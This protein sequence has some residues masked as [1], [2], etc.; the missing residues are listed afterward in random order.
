M[1]VEDVDSV[2]SCGDE[3]ILKD[4]DDFI[5]ED[6]NGEQILW[7]KRSIRLPY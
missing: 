4:I 7:K 5:K 6:I 2:R 3:E 1:E